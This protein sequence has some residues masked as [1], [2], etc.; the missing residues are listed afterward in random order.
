M[1]T[2]DKG[3]AYWKG[4]K[5]DA[6]AASLQAEEHYKLMLRCVERATR[7]VNK[8]EGQILLIAPLLAVGLI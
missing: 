2:K 6:Q 5:L 1:R 8:L 3:L 7:Q 4:R